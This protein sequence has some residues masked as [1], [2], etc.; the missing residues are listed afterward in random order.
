M[1]LELVTISGYRI[2]IIPN[3]KARVPNS[4][5]ALYISGPEGDSDQVHLEIALSPIDIEDLI[6]ML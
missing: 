6:H 3:P 1:A 4:D 5:K 2:R